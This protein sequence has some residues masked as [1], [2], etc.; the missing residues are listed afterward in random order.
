MPNLSHL[1]LYP[2]RGQVGQGGQAKRL[3]PRRGMYSGSARVSLN[4]SQW[5]MVCANPKSATGGCLVL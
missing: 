1:L 5:S 3:S 2:R 4:E